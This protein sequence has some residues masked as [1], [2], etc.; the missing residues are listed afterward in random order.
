MAQRGEQDVMSGPSPVYGTDPILQDEPAG[1][2]TA[3]RIVTWAIILI[4]LV[5]LAAA[6]VFLVKGV[7]ALIAVVSPI[8]VAGMLAWLVFLTIRVLRLEK[9]LDDA[10]RR[11]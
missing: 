4:V 9:R 2:D 6:A 5:V 11:P 1:S 8:L 10:A 7:I 3:T